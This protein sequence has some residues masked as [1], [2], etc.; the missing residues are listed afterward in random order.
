MNAQLLIKLIIRI[1]LPL[2]PGL[3][4]KAIEWIR[5]WVAEAEVIGT[6][7]RSY[8]EEKIKRN[9][10]IFSNTPRRVVNFAVETAVLDQSMTENP[11]EVGNGA[12]AG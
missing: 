5:R 6:N 9:P 2:L 10:E 8:V 1:L 11:V 4:E 12:G 7:K 3:T